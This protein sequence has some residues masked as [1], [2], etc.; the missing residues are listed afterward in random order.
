[1]MNEGGL[2]QSRS[3]RRNGGILSTKAIT[4]TETKTIA[5]TICPHST[6][7]PHREG[8]GVGLYSCLI[9][10]TGLALAACQLW[11]KTARKEARAVMKMARA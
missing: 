4:K 3:L 1:M 11:R 10:S 8:S 2:R 7:L 5:E 6:P 9:L